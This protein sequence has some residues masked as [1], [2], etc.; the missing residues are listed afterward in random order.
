MHRPMNNQ[1]ITHISPSSI[2]L[3]KVYDVNVLAIGY[4]RTRLERQVPSLET[5]TSL[6]KF[7]YIKP[8]NVIL[9]DRCS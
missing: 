1:S 8:A 2:Y 7:V 4:N 6:Y 3:G 5:S 9:P